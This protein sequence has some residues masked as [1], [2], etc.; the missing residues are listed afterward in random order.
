[1]SWRRVATPDRE[2]HANEFLGVK[3]EPPKRSLLVNGSRVTVLRPSGV[4]MLT[5]FLLEELDYQTSLQELSVSA[6]K[7]YFYKYL[8][9][10][11]DTLC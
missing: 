6:Y 8:C 1:M 4:S 3:P 10:L 11:K 2:R 5:N 9:F 7:L